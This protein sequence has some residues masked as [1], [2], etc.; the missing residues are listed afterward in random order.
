MTSKDCWY[1]IKKKYNG[2]GVTFTCNPKNRCTACFGLNVFLSMGNTVFESTR[3]DSKT[4]TVYDTCAYTEIYELMMLYYNVHIGK[5]SLSANYCHSNW[6][7]MV[8]T[9]M[10]FSV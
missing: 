1:Y 5:C 8:Y 9:A 10:K 3:P 7:Q 2:T 6:I 4:S